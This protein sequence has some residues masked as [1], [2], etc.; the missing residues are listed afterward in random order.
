MLQ[1]ETQEKAK[2]QTLANGAQE[3]AKKDE[4]MSKSANVQ[5]KKTMENSLAPPSNSAIAKVPSNAPLAAQ[6]S[7]QTQQGDKN[8]KQDGKPDAKIDP[9][10]GQPVKEGTKE[11]KAQA[12][13]DG[14]DESDRTKK[15]LNSKDNNR[16]II[17]CQFSVLTLI[18]VAYF[19]MNYFL[20]LDLINNVQLA[21][22]NLYL[23]SK[24]PS[25]LKYVVVFTYDEIATG[26]A[27]VYKGISGRHPK[28][29][30]IRECRYTTQKLLLQPYLFE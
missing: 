9:K 20:T 4:G 6:S 29:R 24:R 8:G 25:I 22:T 18:F 14:E 27:L 3:N 15:L 16:K 2:S 26:S 30:V 10:N 13:G 11:E 21:Y 7:S 12:E 19:V 1:K 23:I 17:I 28:R 5:A